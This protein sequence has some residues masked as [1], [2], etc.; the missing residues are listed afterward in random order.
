M[1]IPAVGLLPPS[2]HVENSNIANILQRFASI[3]TK[4]P[5]EGKVIRLHSKDLPFLLGTVAP[6]FILKL[7]LI[8]H[9][10]LIYMT[11]RLIKA[12]YTRFR[13]CV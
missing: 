8:T 5:V 4:L 13:G 3:L 2:G 12:F 7:S 6:T 11:S 9:L 10:I 1:G